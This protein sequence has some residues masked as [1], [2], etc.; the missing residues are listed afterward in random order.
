MYVL[1]CIACTHARHAVVVPDSSRTACACA[2]MHV[3]VWLCIRFCACP[4]KYSSQ[5]VSR[6]L[7][8]CR[9]MC[10]CLCL[11]LRPRVL[12]LQPPR[13]SRQ[14]VAVAANCN[15]SSAPTAGKA[16]IDHQRSRQLVYMLRFTR[17]LASDLGLSRNITKTCLPGRQLVALASMPGMG[18]LPP[19][20]P[21]CVSA[22][23]SA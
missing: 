15:P 11:C 12:F 19:K 4:D 1:L 14:Q 3:Y 22:G 6:Y 9:V 18:H 21:S 20:L 7:I 16:I 2:V 5:P 13:P 17:L 8:G 10:L 23:L